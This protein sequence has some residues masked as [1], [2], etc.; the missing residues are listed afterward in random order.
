V[1]HLVTT[2][3]ALQN[4]V[5]DVIRDPAVGVL[6][7]DERLIEGSARERIRETEGRWGGLV[8]VLPAP[9]AAARLEDDYA[10]QLIRRAIGYQVRV[11]L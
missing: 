6:V 2:P 8:I 3:E 10:R 4:T 7:I 1:R 5:L 9:A 11:N